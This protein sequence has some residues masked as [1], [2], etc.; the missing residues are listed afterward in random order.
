MA[1]QKYKV[2]DLF[3]GCGGISEGYSLA[4][5]DI[6]GGI[7]FNENATKT[8]QHNFKKAKVYDID[9]TTFSDDQIRNEY[10]DVDI[11][12]GG[13]PCQGFS[14]ANRWQKEMEDP[15]NKLFFEYIRF[16]QV[17]RPKVIMIENVRGLLTRDNGY[18]IE[19]IKEI[20][21]SEDYNITYKVLDAS[22]YGVPQNR[23]RAIIIGIRKEFKDTF[24]D[25][26]L[27]TKQT[28][29]TVEDAIGELYCMEQSPA[30]V[31]RIE[32]VADTPLRKYFRTKDSI[33]S[34]QDI[35]YPAAIVQERI[36]HVPQGG[37]WVN[38][39]AD[40]WPSNRQNRHSSAYKRLDPKTQSCTIDTGNAHSNYFHPIYN[41]IPTI[42]ESARLQSFPDSFEF[43]GPRGSKYR[44][45]GNA[46]PP[47]LAKAIADAI[48][49]TI[50]N[51]DN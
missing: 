39:P 22:E 47:L 30:G 19:R 18:A 26:N 45:I 29:T 10:G 38:V 33:I 4:G 7:D 24:F 1:K 34:D 37:N 31:K 44:Q 14:S 15:R 25:F 46:V 32:T 3:C 28:K 51:E 2:L 23:K 35:V 6:A 17:I 40:L 13:P 42:R 36:K 27:I 9:I 50:S 41:R 49:K 11:I 16:V 8:F 21:G 43:I 5:F 48:M 20:L 12:V